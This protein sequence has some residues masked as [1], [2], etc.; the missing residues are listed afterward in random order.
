MPA[1]SPLHTGARTSFKCATGMRMGD[2]LSKDKSK[3]P[4]QYA[5]G[6]FCEKFEVRCEAAAR[7][8]LRP[9]A[10]DN[11][12]WVWLGACM[13]AHG[14]AW[15]CSSIAWRAFAAASISRTASCS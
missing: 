9:H 14:G 15:W 3:L 1:C 7:T 10:Q 2:V 12:M 13:V 4:E 6:V 8:W 5:E 11:L